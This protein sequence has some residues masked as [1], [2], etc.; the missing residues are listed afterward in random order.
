MFE[1]ENWG[2]NGSARSE[3]T[4][5]VTSVE[6]DRLVF[7]VI[8]RG[9]RGERKG[10]EIRTIQLNLVEAG[11]LRFR[12]FQDVFRFPLTV[13]TR[14]F[15]IERVQVDTGRTI[16]MEGV[17]DTRALQKIRIPAGEFD[18]HEIVVSGRYIDHASGNSSRY[19]SRVWYSPSVNFYVKQMFY[20]RNAADTVDFI[21]LNQEMKSFELKQ[22]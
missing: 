18:T 10:Q 19:E 3:V 11:N 2:S 6:S 7:D 17:V 13:G 4:R 20:E 16:R 8:G 9:D 21:R 1:Q 22:R 15:A 12:P 14:T 5:I